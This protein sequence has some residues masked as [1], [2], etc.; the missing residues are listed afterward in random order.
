LAFTDAVAFGL[1]CCAPAAVKIVP[2][3]AST[4]LQ[5]LIGGV[6]HRVYLHFGNILAHDL[7]RHARHLLLFLRVSYL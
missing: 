1:Q 7:H 5:G 4:H 6:D 3:Y 2:A